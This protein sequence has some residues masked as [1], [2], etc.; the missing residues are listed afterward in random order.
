LPTGKRREKKEEREE[1]I[2]RQE[3]CYD[4]GKAKQIYII[5]R[6]KRLMISLSGMKQRVGFN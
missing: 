3:D 2:R 6:T 5:L 4:T 1:N